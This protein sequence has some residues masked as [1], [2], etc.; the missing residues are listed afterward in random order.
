[1]SSYTLELAF[2]AAIYLRSVYSD[3]TVTTRLVVAK[4]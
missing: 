1:M 3:G 4:T 2:A